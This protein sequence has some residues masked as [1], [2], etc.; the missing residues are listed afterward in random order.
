MVS[1]NKMRREDN[2]TTLLLLVSQFDNL[3][4]LINYVEKEKL[5]GSEIF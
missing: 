3:Q 5:H 4:R 2:A 1:G